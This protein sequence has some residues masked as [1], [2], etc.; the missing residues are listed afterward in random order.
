MT[1]STAFALTAK[2]HNKQEAETS[3][4]KPYW[5][6]DL[7]RD[8]A[9]FPEQ[10]S[11]FESRAVPF[12][13]GHDINVGETWSFTVEE[14]PKNDGTANV[15]RNILSV[16]EKVAFSTPE[17]IKEIQAMPTEGDW[18]EHAVNARHA[19]TQAVLFMGYRIGQGVECDESEVASVAQVFMDSLINMNVSPVKLSPQTVPDPQTEVPRPVRSGNSLAEQEALYGK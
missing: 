6:I 13:K 11:M 14:K 4:K 3:S 18:R 9:R 15:W 1:T 5:K 16:G 10:W 19:L 2:V 7:L 17:I 12:Q 8:D